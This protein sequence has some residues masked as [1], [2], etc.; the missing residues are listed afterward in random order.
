MPLSYLYYKAFNIFHC[1]FENG[2]ISLYIA[3]FQGMIGI[4]GEE[5]RYFFLFGQGLNR[6]SFGPWIGS[7]MESNTALKREGEGVF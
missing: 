6:I 3:G 5:K 7:T 2:N 1:G 4:R